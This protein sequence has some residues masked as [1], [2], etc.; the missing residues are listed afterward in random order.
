MIL[1]DS[2][3]Y[4]IFIK[5][6]LRRVISRVVFTTQKKQLVVLIPV[7][8]D[9]AKISMACC[10]EMVAERNITQAVFLY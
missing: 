7:A 5:A 9:R 10:R 4:N 1:R 6:F 3:V 2:S 8:K